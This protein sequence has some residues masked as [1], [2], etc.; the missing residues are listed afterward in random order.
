MLALILATKSD[1]PTEFSRATLIGQPLSFVF[2]FFLTNF[3]RTV[4]P[5][6]LISNWEGQIKE[7]CEQDAIKYHVYYGAGRSIS[8]ERLRK[9]DVVITTY[10]VVAGEYTGPTKSGGGQGPSKKQKTG[11]GLFGMKWKRIILDEGHTIRNPRTKMSKAVCALEAQRR[12]VV[13][14]TPI[15]SF[16]TR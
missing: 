5:L 2:S 11:A 14:G 9:Y 13:T 16:T 4:V 7:H 3:I 8:P 10:Q 6:S 15:V 12:W 1:K